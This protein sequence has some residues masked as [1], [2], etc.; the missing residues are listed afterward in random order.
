ML[1]RTFIKL[2]DK[3]GI[4]LKACVTTEPATRL[5]MNCSH[6]PLATRLYQ[7]P[8]KRTVNKVIGH[9]EHILTLS[10]SVVIKHIATSMF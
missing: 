1:Q 7:L 10:E 6:L 2:V 3:N 5:K 9:T 8:M 4:G